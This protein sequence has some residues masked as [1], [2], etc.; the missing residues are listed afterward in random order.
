MRVICE[1]E[2]LWREINPCEHLDKGV[3]MLS[4]DFVLSHLAGALY[5][6]RAG[7]APPNAD[8][9]NIKGSNVKRQVEVFAYFIANRNGMENEYITDVR[10]TVK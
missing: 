6:P 5:R 10:G 8:C 1:Q 7:K 3:S 2:E 4:A 9:R